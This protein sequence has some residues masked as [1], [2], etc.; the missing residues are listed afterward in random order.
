MA[1]IKKVHDMEGVLKIKFDM[2]RFGMVAVD[3]DGITKPVQK[4]T[5]VL[6]NSHEV[7]QRLRRDCPNR[8]PDKSCHHA[9]AKLEGGQRCKQ[10]QVHPRDFCRAIREGVAAQRRVDA[11]NLVAMDVMS[12][13]ELNGMGRDVLHEGHMSDDRYEAYNDVSNEELIPSMVTA[14]R[15]EEL[16]YFKAM[17]VYKYAPIA[18]CLKV[19]DKAPIGT[20]W[21]DTNE[22][23]RARPNYRS[24][25]VAK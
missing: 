19:T 13:E 7:A 23:D 6:T 9:H 20:R 1:K 10:A 25:L 4:R 17:K 11:M 22:G 24:R 12:V 8:C 21:I 18:E 2:C 3:V 16:D 5:A 14:A 15:S